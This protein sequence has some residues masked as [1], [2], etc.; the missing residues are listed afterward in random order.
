MET[1]DAEAPVVSSLE[2][3][4]DSVRGNYADPVTVK[5]EA[6][7]DRKVD[8]VEVSVDGGALHVEG[9]RERLVRG[10]RQRRPH[11]GRTRGRLVRQ[12]RRDP[13]R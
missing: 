1:V 13:A 10:G 3:E 7:D 6:Q 5:V 11:G 9:R 8:H 4:G 2:L 12:R